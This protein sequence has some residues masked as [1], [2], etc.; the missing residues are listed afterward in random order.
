MNLNY[1]IFYFV[2]YLIYLLFGYNCLSRLIAN[3]PIEVISFNHSSRSFVVK[4]LLQLS[5]ITLLVSGYILANMNNLDINL[6]CLGVILNLTVIIFYNIK[7]YPFQDNLTYYFHIVWAIPIFI[8]HLFCK[9]TGSYNI[10]YTILY[11]TLLLVYKYALEK[12]VY[13]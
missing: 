10:F 3:K 13:H 5:L 4:R 2:L 12:Y 6:Y 7:W 1:L 9:F 11:V 8:I